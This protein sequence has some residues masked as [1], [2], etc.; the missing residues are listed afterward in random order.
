MA[1]SRGSRLLVLLAA[2]LAACSAT[3]KAVT[4]SNQLMFQYNRQREEWERIVPR[5]TMEI[6]QKKLAGI[7][8]APL[9]VHEVQIED[10]DQMKE[11]L[12]S[13]RSYLLHPSVNCV[14]GRAVI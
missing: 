11:H 2:I 3:K 12:E 8:D 6:S 10:L 1:V 9:T 14:L 7:K 13:V 5:D 4:Q